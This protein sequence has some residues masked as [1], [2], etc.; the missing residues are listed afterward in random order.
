MAASYTKVPESDFRYPEPGSAVDT[1]EY[2]L[3]VGIIEF[4]PGDLGFNLGADYQYTRYVYDGVAS[5]NRDLH[6][7]Q[8]PVGF[9]YQ[10]R[11]WRLDGYIAPGVSTSSN[12]MKDLLNKGSRDDVIVDVRAEATIDATEHRAWLTGLA[13]DRA[14]GTPV[15]YPVFGALFYLGNKLRF[16]VAFPDPEVR[17]TPSARQRLVVRLF[18][19]GNEWHVSSDE[20]DD[21]FDYE[22]KAWR[23][24]ATWTLGFKNIV[25]IDLAAGYEFNRSQRFADDVGRSIHADLDDQA[26][27]SI[28]LR[29]GNAPI[30]YTNQIAR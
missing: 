30:P 20:L 3:V 10:N 22:V 15:P 19:A 27:A 25:W 29:L 23:A 11:A 16:R 9:D 6:R 5:R 24:R 18:P 1:R 4:G 12:V 13:Y 2:R 28:G 14:F 8:L 21:D 7:L 26:F 17:Y